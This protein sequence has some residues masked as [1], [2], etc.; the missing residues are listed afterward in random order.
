[1]ADGTPSDRGD[2]LAQALLGLA[3]VM[4]WVSQWCRLLS[5]STDYGPL[6]FM[7]LMMVQDLV[8]IPLFEPTIPY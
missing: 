1:M 4:L 3:L 8:P 2:R 5:R 6:V 7:A